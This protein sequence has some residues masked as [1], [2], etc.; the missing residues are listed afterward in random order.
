MALDMVVHYLLLV[1]RCRLPVV[2][3]LAGNH[4]PEILHLESRRLESH[5]ILHL[6]HRHQDILLDRGRRD[7]GRRDR[8][9]PVLRLP[10]RQVH[11]GLA[12]ARSQGIH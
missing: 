8:G 3:C 6:G 2:H 4:R 11:L 7:R 1:E 5:R 9:H 10:V 12:K